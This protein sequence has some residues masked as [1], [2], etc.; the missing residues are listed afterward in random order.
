MSQIS[1]PETQV[2]LCSPLTASPGLNSPNNNNNNTPDI[3]S[4]D[5]TYPFLKGIDTISLNR[6]RRIYIPQQ[7][8]NNMTDMERQY[9]DIKR[10]YFNIIILF[11]KGKFYE[12]YDCDAVIAQKEFGLKMAG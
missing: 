4:S 6:P 11:K 9:W 2:H 10:D 3:L 7:Y 5:Y 1:S 8:I 12:L